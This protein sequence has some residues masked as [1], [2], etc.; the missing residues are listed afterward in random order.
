MTA[1][2]LCFVA[3]ECGE[4]MEYKPCGDPCMPSCSDIKGENCGDL[5]ACGEGCFCKSGHVFDGK[6]CIPQSSC[7]C[8]IESLGIFIN[9]RHLRSMQVVRDIE[10]TKNILMSCCYSLE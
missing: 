1:T 6:K 9:V 8:Q 3:M 7:G 10:C 4:N 2:G 5:G